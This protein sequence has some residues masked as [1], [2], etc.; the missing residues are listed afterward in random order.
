MFKTYTTTKLL[1]VAHFYKISGGHFY[2]NVTF[3]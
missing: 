3:E 1:D 2:N